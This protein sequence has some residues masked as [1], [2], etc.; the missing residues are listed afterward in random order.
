MSYPAV[1]DSGFN[2][3]TNTDWSVTHGINFSSGDLALFIFGANYFADTTIPNGYTNLTPS[4]G[5]KIRPGDPDIV[6]YI[7]YKYMSGI[8]N[9]PAT[10]TGDFPGTINNYTHN[11]TILNITGAQDPAIAPLVFDY[12]TDDGNN[13]GAMPISPSVKANTDSL[14]CRIGI[15]NNRDVLSFPQDY[16]YNVDFSNSQTPTTHFITTNIPTTTVDATS[17]VYTN[18]AASFNATLLIPINEITN[19]PPKPVIKNYVRRNVSDTTWMI[20]VEELDLQD[21]DLVLWYMSIRP[22]NN[23]EPPSGF[24][25]IKDNYIYSDDITIN[26]GYKY[27]EDASLEPSIYSG[28]IDSSSTYELHMW[29]ISGAVNPNQV[30]IYE[31]E[32]TGTIN[33]NQILMPEIPDLGSGVTIFRLS[34]SDGGHI[35]GSTNNEP[36]AVRYFDD[37]IGQT[38]SAT[39]AFSTTGGS[40]PSG[41]WLTSNLNSDFWSTTIAFYASGSG[42]APD[43]GVSMINDLFILG[44]NVVN[45]I[46]TIGYSYTGTIPEANSI[47][48]W[49]RNSGAGFEDISGATSLKYISISSDLGNQI[50]YGVTPVDNSGTTGIEVF[51]SAIT[52]TSGL[53]DNNFVRNSQDLGSYTQS[54]ILYN[55]YRNTYIS[56]VTGVYRS[57]IKE[58]E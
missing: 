27:L 47:Y 56:N 16:N 6:A 46:H 2:R 1:V 24:T 55:L 10:Y 13:S 5:V 30:S 19:T 36:Y 23:V 58:Y 39:V 37:Q 42:P 14:L 15:N 35:T 57:R 26:L 49:Q 33:N 25:L 8:P 50:R 32:L 29:S 22:D 44:S 20:N 7:A 17:W 41:S 34:T 40:S 52:L 48:R 12:L 54:E 28:S 18:L 38:T 51:S 9:E 21:N 31:D 3:D 53:V 45:N 4:G 11:V 43:G